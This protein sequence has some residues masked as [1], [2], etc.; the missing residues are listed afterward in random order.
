MNNGLFTGW[1]EGSSLPRRPMYAQT[2]YTSQFVTPPNDASHV[3]ILIAGGGG[4]GGGGGFASATTSGGG[5]GGGG[6]ASNYRYRL[7]LKML[8]SMNVTKFSVIIG[9]GGTAGAGTSTDPGSGTG[10]GSGGTTI[11]SFPFTLS[12][13]RSVSYN[14]EAGGGAGG[15]GGTSTT[16]G[17]QGTPGGSSS[18]G[19]F[20]GFNGAQGQTGGGIFRSPDFGGRTYPTGPVMIMGGG[21]GCGKNNQSWQHWE[22]P[23]ILGVRSSSGGGNA[24]FSL[25]GLSSFE[26][27]SN[28]VNTWVSS[29]TCAPSFEELGFL[30][31]FGGGFATGGSA[32]AVSNG[33]KGG[34]GWRGTGGGGGGGAGF[35]GS[36]SGAGGKGGSGFATFFWEFF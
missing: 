14:Y 20:A 5:G 18:G 9:A 7:P 33:G 1:G 21:G 17:S 32:T 6:A 15:G 3:S 8:A 12:G 11:I 29:F 34:D 22:P 26:N 16:G 35:A 13:N 4:G 24:D 23:I 31:I 28:L 27:Y 25:N 30:G 2:I 36:A 19:N 10:G